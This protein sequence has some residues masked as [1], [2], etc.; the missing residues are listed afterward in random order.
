[1]RL[2]LQPNGDTNPE[3]ARTVSSARREKTAEVG[4]G[5]QQHQQRHR[6]KPV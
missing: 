5:G 6:H 1:M 4:A 3:F 2:R